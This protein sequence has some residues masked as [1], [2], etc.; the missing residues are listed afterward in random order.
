MTDSPSAAFEGSGANLH[1]KSRCRMLLNLVWDRGS[2]PFSPEPMSPISTLTTDFSNLSAC[3]SDTPKRFLDLSN[4]SNCGDPLPSMA[5]SS[6]GVTDEPDS[7]DPNALHIEEQWHKMSPDIRESKKKTHLRCIDTAVPRM[8]CSSPKMHNPPIRLTGRGSLRE[9]SP[10]LGKNTDNQWYRV[11]AAVATKPIQKEGLLVQNPSSGPL[12]PDMSEDCDMRELGSPITLVPHD[13]APATDDVIG[14]DGID[15]FS[16]LLRDNEPENFNTTSMSSSMAMLF[17]GP[18]MT[19]NLEISNVS[20]SKGRL[21]RSPSMP[22]KLNRPVLKRSVAHQGNETPI[23]TKRRRSFDSPIHE[24]EDKEN[25]PELLRLRKTLSLCD[26]DVVKVLDEDSSH[27]QLIGDFSKVYV[28]PTVAGRHQDLKYISAET[29]A[30]LL[31]GEFHS[32][33]EKY[34]I[35]DCRYPYEYNG[36]HIKGAL[37]LHKL[38]EVYE[39]FLANPLIP[40]SENK[41]IIIIFHCEFSSERGPRMCRFLR[42][43]DRSLNEYPVLYYPE[44]Y[45]LKGGYKDFYHEYEEFCDPRGYC[46]MHHKDYKE[47]LLKFRTKSRSWAA[48]RRRREQI[49]RLMKM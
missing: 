5:E 12:L 46:P 45:V 9:A 6:E 19:H 11:P 18:L 16:E 28:L 37:N 17:S 31:C 21:Y 42:E 3:N 1:M 47:E 49:T 48:E 41:R 2:V 29:L 32:L 43:E 20:L 27:C 24:E 30:A 15:G 7:P 40:K 4:L 26:V 38:N 22:E 25:E 8:L 44:L 10:L 36:G 33:I 34:F 14:L 23:K 13:T 35:I 39:Y